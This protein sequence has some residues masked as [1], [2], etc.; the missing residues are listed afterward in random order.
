MRVCLVTGASGSIGFAICRRLAS[1][2]YSFA[3]HC[4]G[5]RSAAEALRA[6]LHGRGCDAEIFQADLSV[7]G[8]AQDLVERVLRRFAHV[9]ALVYSAGAAAR[10]LF[11]DVEEETWRK[12]CEINLGGAFFTAQR[13][14]RDMISRKSGNILFVSSMWG[15]A[16]ASCE[17][18]YSA[19]K[20]GMIGLCRSLAKEL[21]PSGIRVNCVAPGVIDTPMNANLSEDEMRAL[22]EDTPLGRIGTAEDVAS[23]VAFLL[24]DEASFI[25]G[26]TLSVDG[27]FIL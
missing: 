6:E 19:A 20:A 27:G 18:A 4:N 10:E 7:P 16:G 5:N 2:Q 25:T 24:S 11:T 22:A 9:D 14:A 1:E 23:A 8:Q 12:T 15:I 21:G 26:Q 3:L 13:C 17:A